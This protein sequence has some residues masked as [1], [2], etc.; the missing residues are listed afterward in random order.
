[1]NASYGMV[2]S[3]FKRKFQL[4][5]GEGRIPHRRILFPA[6]MGGASL[7]VTRTVVAHFA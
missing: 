6:E 7:F 2:L 3:K 4:P 1:M 5:R